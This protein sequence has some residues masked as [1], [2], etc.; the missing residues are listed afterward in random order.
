MKG[1]K[2]VIQH[3]NKVLMNELTAINQYFLHAKMFRNWGLTKLA[4]HEHHESIDEM[5]HADAL[6][7]R[8]LFLDGVPNLQRLS[9][10]RVGENVEEQFRNDLAVEGDYEHNQIVFVAF[11]TGYGDRRAH[12]H[13]RV[14][15]DHVLNL[16][17]RQVLA[18]HADSVTQTVQE[19]EHSVYRLHCCVAGMEPEILE[20]RQRC[21]GLAEIGME[22]NARNTGSDGQVA[23][24]LGRALLI[25]FIADRHPDEG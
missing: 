24:S 5:K 16:K 10:L 18:A 6:I 13:L 14:L 4:D 17:G 3:L 22:Q 25:P 2:K 11:P 12:P 23:T 8:I 7:D 19:I 1:D 20:C 9:A 15:V 21:L